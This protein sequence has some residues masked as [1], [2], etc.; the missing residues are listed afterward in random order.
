MAQTEEVKPSLSRL[1]EGHP[2]P[3]DLDPARIPAGPG[4][5]RSSHL[6][7]ARA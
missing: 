1:L 6:L 4:D 7:P 2:R 3:L 5:S